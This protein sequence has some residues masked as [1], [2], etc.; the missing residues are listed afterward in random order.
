MSGSNPLEAVFKHLRSAVREMQT[1]EGA[2]PQAVTRFV[3][4]FLDE[5]GGDARSVTIETGYPQKLALNAVEFLLRAQGFDVGKGADA[6]RG[7]IQARVSRDF[8]NRPNWLATVQSGRGAWRFTIEVTARVASNGET[9]VEMS[10]A[11]SSWLE[12]FAEQLRLSLKQVPAGNVARE[13]QV[14]SALA[15]SSIGDTL[16]APGER[17]LAPYSG[18]LRDYSGC[19]TNEEVEDLGAGSDGVLPLG[20]WAFERSGD[21]M[22][23]RQMR[24]ASLQRGGRRSRREHQG[25][26]ICAP[27]NAGKTELLVGWARA[28]NAAGYNL[29]IVDVKG[30]MLE[31]LCGGYEWRG[32]LFHVSTDPLLTPNAAAASPCHAINVLDGLDAQSRLT[33]QRVRQIAEA[34]LPGEGL[35][36]GEARVW[37]SN[38]LN[39]LT[40]L[41]H[42][43][44]LEQFYWPLSDRD[45]DL[46][47]V[48]DL[49]SDETVLL[50]TIARIDD[51]ER[52]NL[53]DGAAPIEPGLHSWFSDIA[54]LL[55]Q[56]EIVAADDEFNRRALSGAR[57]EY[58]FRWLTEQLTSALRPFRRG[59]L[60]Y[61]K[62]SGRPEIERFR[63]ERL[64]GLDPELNP[65]SQQ[66]TL[67]LAAREQELDEA[68]TLLTLAI[69]KLQH[70]LYERMRHTRTRPLAPVLLLLDETRRIRNFKTNEYVSFAREAEAGCVVVYQFLDQI[71]DERQYPRAVGQ[72]RDANLSRLADRRHGAPV[73]RRLTDAGPANLP[74]H[75][76]RRR[77]RRRPSDWRPTDS[78]FLDRRSARASRRAVSGADLSAPAAGAKANSGDVR[79]RA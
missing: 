7:L 50:E 41:I 30:N 74:D 32:E 79:S 40:A 49:A 26:L 77:R 71:G 13:R 20:R 75:G 48:Y 31:K 9:T 52:K 35:D 57:A 43:V 65:S 33:L 42:L 1:R 70:A 78:V 8:G 62:V 76:G 11:M 39:W 36:R 34:L 16:L 69:V 61:E 73:H 18:T 54:V 4:Q 10:P 21:M 25:A 17:L 22:L 38:W 14:Q 44:L 47:D 15:L 56:K 3:E 6:A 67:V 19:A 66:T 12:S 68:Q 29:L 59:G 46:G 53:R 72:Y 5:V 51:A 60:L 64:A 55:P 45:P 23:G 24:L 28:A 27:Q 63:L 37:R 58:S 2:E